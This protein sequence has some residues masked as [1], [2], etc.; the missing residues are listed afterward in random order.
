[1]RPGL[2]TIRRVINLIVL[3]AVLLP[4]NNLFSNNIQQKPT[5][6]SSTDAFSRG[7][8]EL[9][10]RGFSELLVTFPKDPLYK[11]YSGVCLVKLNRA[12]GRALTLLSQAQQGS[13]TVKAI[14]SDAL[15]FLGRA[16]QMSGKF[17]EAID[18]YNSFAALS[19]KKIARDLGISDY[20]LQCNQG[21]GQI[22]DFEITAD[23]QQK[24]EIQK[25]EEQINTSA[26]VPVVNQKSDGP[27]IPGE[28]DRI[29]S[30]A[31]KNQFSADSL[32]SV[33]E[34]QKK[35]LEKVS[36]KESAG[37]KIRIT[38][39]ENLAASFQKKADQMYTEAQT[40]MNA[41]SF[42]GVENS[43]LNSILK[44]DSSTLKKKTPVNEINS[45]PGKDTSKLSQQPAQILKS[46]SQTVKDSSALPV[47]KKNET[48]PVNKPLDIYSVFEIKEKPVFSA[49]EKVLINP[50]IP[51]GLIYR[52]QVAV[53]RN[54]IAPSYF[55][56]I[57]PVYGFRT[58]G[59]DKT[60]YYAGMFRRMA[61]ANKA[62]SKV[63]QKGFRDAFIVCLSGGKAVSPER[64]A[65]M[66][67]EWGKKAFMTAM[68]I[69]PESTADTIPPALSFR[70]EMSRSLKPLKEEAADV[71]KKLA[72]SRGLMTETLSDGT[73][74]YLIGEFI[75]FESADDYAGLLLRNGY[76][77]AKVTAWLG[78]KEIPVETARKLFERI[79]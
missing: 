63:R 55:K 38:E 52:I 25:A 8:Y 14:P 67:K 36:L 49:N 39:N 71:I 6:Q 32:Y 23:A 10:Y 11:Y 44:T 77:G 62:L 21:K 42:T 18:T 27:V 26:A 56:G 79:E 19:G 35:T 9:A 46:V 50:A 70:V 64:A 29:L 3:F 72:G 17:A 2:Q 40:A 47:I 43:E 69:N 4:E 65:I 48:G 73:V 16:Q 37:L 31:L 15:F 7:D 59:V 20:I 66:E 5:R 54:P 57:T 53:F 30:V 60:N 24:V 33:A 51:P 22:R 28:Y 58:A 13:A 74:V 45:N 1:M 12:P 78:K 68:K 34:S 75:T 76:R 41:V 61:D